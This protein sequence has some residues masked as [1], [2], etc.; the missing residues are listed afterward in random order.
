MSEQAPAPT[1][2]PVPP[3][4]RGILRTVMI[5]VLGLGGGAFGTYFTAV[6]NT[7]IRPSLPVA[8]FSVSADGLTATCQNHATGENGWW[9]FGD[10]SPLEPFQADQPTVTHAYAKPGSYGVKLTVRNLTSDENDRTVA[11]EVSA[12]GKDALPPPKIAAFTVVPA[13]P[14]TMAPATFRATAD[15]QNAEYCVW[16]LGDGRT[17]V[18]EGGG[19]V[20]RLLTFDK[21]GAFSLQ[22]VAHN[23]KEAVKQAAP[24][25][26][27]APPDGTL[28]A[29]L[30]ITD[31]GARVERLIRA[32][33]LAVP[34]KDKAP[35]FSKAIAARPR[36]T[37]LEVTLTGSTVPNVKNIKIAIAAD[38][39][40]ATVT[41]D[42]VNQ[43]R[44]DA[45]IPLSITE[46]KIHTRPATV[47][48]AAGMLQL[49]ASGKASA[50]IPLPPLPPSLHSPHRSIDVEIRQ[51]SQGKVFVMAVGPLV[52][53]GPVTIPARNVYSPPAAALT[54]ASYDVDKVTVSFEIGT[55]TQ[56]GGIRP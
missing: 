31:G 47:T 16:D 10:G 22:L 25:R 15:V 45:L 46:E 42:W 55:I 50:V 1:P 8:N 49:A 19:K 6:F 27:D 30:T 20:D 43:N 33:T 18:T 51:V 39:K 17:E 56:T 14:G 24:V 44:A 7:M 53:R 11:V 36:C 32:E 29:V 26:I 54:T 5:W 21:P 41:G 13:S 34:A 52:G 35:S 23:G 48:H 40:S 3:K 12:A 38:R 37:L 9:D 2:A 4:K 28:T